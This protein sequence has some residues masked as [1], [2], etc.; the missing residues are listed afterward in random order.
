MKKT[1]KIG[2]GTSKDRRLARQQKSLEYKQAQAKK[3]R[4]RK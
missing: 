3:K 4:E 1:Q 2:P